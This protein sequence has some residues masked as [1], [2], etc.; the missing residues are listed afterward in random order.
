[1]GRRP[2]WTCNASEVTVARKLSP[3]LLRV[4]ILDDEGGPG[5][6]ASL[7]CRGAAL[8]SGTET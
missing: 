3:I 2:V 6:F 4:I 7:I 5:M 8:N 1:V